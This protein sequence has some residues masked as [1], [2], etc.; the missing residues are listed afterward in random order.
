MA[1]TVT[2]IKR[3]LSLPGAAQGDVSPSTPAQSLGGFLSISDI[4]NASLNN[5]F[6]TITRLE[7]QTGITLYRCVF[8]L[9]ANA[10][11]TWSA[12][13]AWIE[14]DDAFGGTYAIGVDP[15]GPVARDSA[16][17]QAVTVASGTTAPAGVTFSTPTDA[18]RLALGDLG[19]D[20]C[21][22][23]WVRY[24]V[25]ADPGAAES[26]TGYITIAGIPV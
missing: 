5:L 11:D 20:E 23:L 24:T 14:S 19:P 26:D 21:I 9:N 1:V 10:T 13:E 18:A 6:R 12:V 8:L 17:A 15:T 3:R 22:A 4:A 7:S 25:S 16:V 2:D